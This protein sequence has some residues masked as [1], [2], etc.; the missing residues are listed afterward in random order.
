VKRAQ[1]CN[2][3][4]RRGEAVQKK[5]KMSPKEIED[6]GMKKEGEKQPSETNEGSRTHLQ[7]LGNWK[8]SRAEGGVEKARTK[9]VVTI[10]G[11]K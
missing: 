4:A 8:R 7:N 1:K 2:G 11:G 9:H 6:T 5:K 10:G 3:V